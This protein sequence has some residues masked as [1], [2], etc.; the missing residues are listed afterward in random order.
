MT[1]MGAEVRLS[2]LGLQLPPASKPTGL[3]RPLVI[4]GPLAYTSGHLPVREDGS[5]VTGR[6]GADLDQQA[7][8]AAARQTGLAILATLRA[9]LGSLDRVRRVVKIVGLVH[10]TADFQG[11]PAVI[12]GCSELLAEVF[13]PE[14]GVGA[15]SAFG[16]I[17]LPLGAAVEVEAVF[18]VMT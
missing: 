14:A 2:Q 13:G 1:A 9:E 10:C 6:V 12:N 7:G 8:Y 15:R 16:A 3:Y 18:E 4:V 17:A 5:L 11:Q